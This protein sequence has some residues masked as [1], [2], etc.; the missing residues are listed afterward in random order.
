M[1]FADERGQLRVEVQGERDIRE[2]AGAPEGDFAGMSAGLMDD[3]R[4]GRLGGGRGGGVAFRQVRGV[5]RVGPLAGAG[6][7]P[8]AVVDQFAVL[9]LPEGRVGRIAPG[10]TGTSVRP[11]ISSRRNAW[12][13]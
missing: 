11:M 4:G 7:I 8:G 13:T 12:R 2:R 1:Q 9:F 3:P 5:K 6:E 10:T